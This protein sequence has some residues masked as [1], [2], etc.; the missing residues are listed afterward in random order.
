[1]KKL[2]AV[3]LAVAMLLSLGVT[4]FAAG[5]GEIIILDPPA[6]KTFTAYKIFDAVTGADGKVS[7]TTGTE[8]IGKIFT[9]DDTTKKVTMVDNPALEGLKI[10]PLDGTLTSFQVVKS[11]GFDAKKFA[12]F[13]SDKVT[14]G[15]AS[16]VVDGEVKIANLDPGYYLVKGSD[17][18]LA[19]TNV[20]ENKTVKVQDKKDMP[21]DK[22]VEDENGTDIN[23]QGVSVGD[24]LTYTITTKVPQ[25]ADTVTDYTFILSD[26][27]SEGLTFGNKLTII[28]GDDTYIIEYFPA[29]DNTVAGQEKIKVTATGTITVDG[30]EVNPNDPA[31]IAAAVASVNTQIAAKDTLIETKQGAVDAAQDDVDDAAQDLVDAKAAR[32]AKQ[33]FLDKLYEA[34]RLNVYP[35]TVD[36]TEYNAANLATAIATAEDELDDLNDAVDD[37]QDALD[38]AVDALNTAVG[39]L[40]AVKTEKANLEALLRK[41]QNIGEE[42]FTLVTSETDLLIDPMPN[43]YFTRD[44]F[45]VVGKGVTLEVGGDEFESDLRDRPSDWRPGPLQ[46]ERQDLRAVSRYAQEK[47]RPG[48]RGCDHRVHRHRQRERRCGDPPERR[49][50]GLWRGL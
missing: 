23:N 20:L 9:V 25:L 1:M 48:Q 24:E 40:E 8:W 15:T 5:N 3:L 18:S 38:D 42:G 2:F 43:T 27:M 50:P 14:T 10:I 37:A 13:M 32:D 6:D 46:Q 36:G 21:L 30:V 4:A 19:L 16:A 41:L 35:V 12:A 44:P 29:T 34:R 49:R 11:T 17:D 22:T 26:T 39:E 33:A 45:A 31:S 28:I 47:S 7:Y